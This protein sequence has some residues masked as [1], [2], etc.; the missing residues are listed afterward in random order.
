MINVNTQ[1]LASV[2]RQVLAVLGITFAV[3][4]QSDSALHLPVAISSILGVA[5]AVVIAI[6]H[7]VGDPSTGTPPTNPPVGG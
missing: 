5:G 3:L 2:A 4:T 1:R 7:Y 6:E